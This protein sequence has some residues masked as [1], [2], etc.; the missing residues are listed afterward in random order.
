MM[1]I[2]FLIEYGKT[3]SEDESCISFLLKI[4]QIEIAIYKMQNGKDKS[5]TKIQILE[6]LKELKSLSEK[7]PIRTLQSRISENF[8]N[9][10]ARAGYVDEVALLQY[11][12]CSV[13]ERIEN[14]Q[15]ETKKVFLRKI[16]VSTPKF[17]KQ[18]Y[19]EDLIDFITA[20]D[21]TEEDFE[22]IRSFLVDIS[23]SEWK[24]ENI[25][26]FLAT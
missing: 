10:I 5:I 20:K 21:F 25:L 6:C 8:Q 2:Q 16:F 11:K 15:D 14:I 17:Q 4:L 22:D 7:Y 12:K 26:F 19:R 13:F 23:L 9:Y 18:N 1:Y 24:K 3:E